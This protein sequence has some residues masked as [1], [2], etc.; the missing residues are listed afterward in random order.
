MATSL[1]RDG[2]ILFILSP[3][4]D[5]AIISMGAT[6]HA[7]CAAGIQVSL[8]T[9]F[10]NSNYAPMLDHVDASDDISAVRHCE[11]MIA[12]S[13]L[14]LRTSLSRSFPLPDSSLRCVPESQILCHHLNLKDNL[15]I[16]LHL[17]R[18]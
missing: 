13:Q 15:P 16:L 4:P 7:L 11:N 18:R 5:D 12:A 3:H 10:G 2:S 1:K 6:A 9:C 17:V 14:G 8:I